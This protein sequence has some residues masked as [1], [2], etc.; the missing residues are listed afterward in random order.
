LPPGEVNRATPAAARYRS[1]VEKVSV[2]SAS[3]RLAAEELAELSDDELAERAGA[4]LAF[5]P[6]LRAARDLNEA[7]DYAAQIAAPVHVPLPA[8]A[9]PTLTRFVELRCGAG[10]SVDRRAAKGI[11]RELKAVGGDL[12]SVRLALT[13]RERGP[14]LWAI[15]AALPRDETLRRVDAAL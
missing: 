10:D 5:V 2:A 4:P 7:R 12:R 9:A 3:R 15:V 14:E 1:A 13:G 11:V 8:E 6:A